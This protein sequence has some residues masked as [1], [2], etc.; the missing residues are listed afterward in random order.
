MRDYRLSVEHALELTM[1]IHTYI[2]YN[3][4]SNTYFLSILLYHKSQIRVI[5]WSNEY[6]FHGF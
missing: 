1:S 5:Y 3:Y 2:I 6:C 4:S